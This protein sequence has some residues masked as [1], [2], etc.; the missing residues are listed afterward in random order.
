MNIFILDD[1]PRMAAK[2]HC[3]IHVNKMILE[4]TQMLSTCLRLNGADDEWMIERGIT[5]KAGTPYKKTH[6]HHPAV[7]WASETR[8]NFDWLSDLGYWLLIEYHFRYDKTHGCEKPLMNIIRLDINQS[9]LIKEGEMTD[10]AQ[11]MP[12]EYKVKGD[13]VAAYRDFYINDKA[14]FAKWK[15]STPQPDWW[16][17]EEVVA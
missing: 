8:D 5:T 13:A 11:C 14:G 9:H 3:D 7:K 1:I 4:T 16:P 6:Q 17:H 10:F 12:D 15:H 2:Y